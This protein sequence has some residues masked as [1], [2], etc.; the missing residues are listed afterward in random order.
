[1]GPTAVAIATHGAS[2]LKLS[3]DSEATSSPLIDSA[4][5]RAGLRH[6]KVQQLLNQPRDAAAEPIVKAEDFQHTATNDS[7]AFNHSRMSHEKSVDSLRPLGPGDVG[8][9]P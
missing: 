4:Y 9:R 5:F 7:P 8:Q 2:Q 3:F 6:E 1:M